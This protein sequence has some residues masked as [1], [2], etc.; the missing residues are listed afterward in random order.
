MLGNISEVFFG[1][2][3]LIWGGVDK[4]EHYFGFFPFYMN[5]PDF[6]TYNRF[7]T[8]MFPLYVGLE[9]RDVKNNIFLW[10]LVAFGGNAVDGAIAANAVQGVVAPE[11]CGVGGDLFAIVWDAE[12]EQLYGLNASGRSPGSLTREYFIEQGMDSIPPYGPL[13]VSVPGTVDGWFE[14][15][16]RFGSLPM[17]LWPLAVTP[18]F[19]PARTRSTIMRA[20]V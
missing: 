7:V 11:T 9:K 4:G 14:L 2:I 16:G 3:L 5:I 1:L 8:V 19:W 17:T 15:H 20:P 18:T 13:P 10:P 12:S 6:L